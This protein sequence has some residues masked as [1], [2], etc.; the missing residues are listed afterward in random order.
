MNTHC[1]L[2][3]RVIILPILLKPAWAQAAA[4][5]KYR[6][7]K[8]DGDGEKYVRINADETFQRIN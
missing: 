1:T 6:R 5:S 2:S 7:S 4:K 8:V 3:D